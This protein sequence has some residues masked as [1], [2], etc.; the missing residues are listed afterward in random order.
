MGPKSVSTTLAVEAPALTAVKTSWAALQVADKQQE[1]RGL[2]FGRALFELRESSQVRRNWLQ[3]IEELGIPTATAYRWINRFEE[4]I[5]TRS[6]PI[7]AT[8]V[9]IESEPEQPE[10]I[11]EPKTPQTPMTVEE[12]DNQQLRDFTHRLVSVT[13]A[14]KTLIV[15]NAADCTEYP[16][17]VNAAKALAKVIETL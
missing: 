3:I 15:N 12:R 5:G 10:P 1:K 16:N 14:M 13:S 4:S 17:M 7:P 6:A 9:V 11:S 8:P 2:Q